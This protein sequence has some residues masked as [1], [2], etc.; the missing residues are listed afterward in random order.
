MLFKIDQLDKNKPQK[1]NSTRTFIK[2]KKILA[3]S[4]IFN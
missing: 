4:N 2:I 1:T 3:V